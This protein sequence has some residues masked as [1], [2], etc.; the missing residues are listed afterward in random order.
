MRYQKRHLI[1]IIPLFAIAIVAMTI[2]WQGSFKPSWM[3]SGEW[4][5]FSCNFPS[6]ASPINRIYAIRPTGT[7][8]QLLLESHVPITS[9]ELSP[10]NQY[11]L[12][13]RADVIYVTTPKFTELQTLV[14]P[15]TTLNYYRFPVWSPI[16]NKIAFVS[17]DEDVNRRDIYQMNVDGSNM[18]RLSHDGEIVDKIDWS[19]NGEWIAYTT[20]T[21]DR[22]SRLEMIDKNGTET[23]QIA[24]FDKLAFNPSWSSDGSKILFQIM[25]AAGSSSINIIDTRTNHI[26]K[27][28]VTGSPTSPGWSPND[29][30]IVFAMERKIFVLSL[31]NNSL[32]NIYELADCFPSDFDWISID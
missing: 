1:V 25:E 8:L 30:Q 18:L 32:T 26:E 15:E 31:D 6:L 13:T 27:L 21:S 19:P 11:F 16:E 24:D 23:R 17:N 2:L 22:F 14:L 10:D 28:D 29:N 12:F 4:L 20:M 3:Q 5:T 7:D 9:L